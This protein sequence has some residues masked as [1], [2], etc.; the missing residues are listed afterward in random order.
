[1]TEGATDGG[2]LGLAGEGTASWDD[3]SRSSAEQATDRAADAPA[4]SALSFTA[5]VPGAWSGVEDGADGVCSGGSAVAPAP[6]RLPCF[7]YGAEEVDH[8]RS[9]DPRL[10]AVIDRV[11]HIYRPVIPDLFE[12]LVNSIVAQQISSRALATIWGRMR[13]RFAPLTPERLASLAPEDVQ[14]CGM[15]LRKA[16]YIVDIADRVASGT[17]DLDPV[18]ISSLSD[19]EVCAELVELPGI[20]TWTAEMLLTFSL[21]RPD[22]MSY[23][24]LAILR[25]LR[26]VYHHRVITPELFAR[27]KRRYSPYAT[28][29]SLYLWAI[30][31]GALPDMRDYAPKKPKPKGKGKGKGRPSG[32]RASEPRAAGDPG[33]VGRVR[34]P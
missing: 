9:R 15:T 20:G 1:M 14:R 6:P 10:G 25:G 8:L 4:P 30:A 34:H 21:Q 23:R 26:M 2:G 18:R 33:D 22:V 5:F 17:L 11:G 32:V 29:A 16:G 19:E 12:A 7:E 28:T 31:G 24:D 13:E 3:A 27:Y